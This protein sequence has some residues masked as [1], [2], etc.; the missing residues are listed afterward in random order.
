MLFQMR[1]TKILLLLFF[2]NAK[3]TPTVLLRSSKDALLSGLFLLRLPHIVWY[4][5][6]S[7]DWAFDDGG[8]PPKAVV[9]DWL[10]LIKVRFR[11]KTGSCIAVHCVA[12]LGRYR[13]SIS[14]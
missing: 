8:A 10:N 5:S 9:E 7:Q 12:G 3:S 6:L 14:D 4:L 11:D 2:K 1:Q 13:L